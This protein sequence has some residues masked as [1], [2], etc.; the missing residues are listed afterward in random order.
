VANST[1]SL[2]MV[3]PDR[4]SHPGVTLFMRSNFSVAK[5]ETDLMIKHVCRVSVECRAGAP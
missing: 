5:R 3:G 4:N 2:R 1:A